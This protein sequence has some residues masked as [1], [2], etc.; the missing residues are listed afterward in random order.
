MF[1][2]LIENTAHI[3]YKDLLKIFREIIFHYHDDN[4]EDSLSC[5]PTGHHEFS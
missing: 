5:A 1:S 4:V 2:Y 3:H